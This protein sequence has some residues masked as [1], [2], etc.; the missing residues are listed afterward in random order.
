MR[1]FRIYRTSDTKVIGESP[2]ISEGIFHSTFD[3]SRNLSMLL[4]EKAKENLEVPKAKLKKKA[5][6]VDILS[7]SF[8]SPGQFFIST[9]L[10]NILTKY[11]Y[12]GLEF[13][14]T[15][16]ISNDKE[17]EDYWII[18]PFK[19][20]FSFLDISNSE[21]VFTDSMGSVVNEAI[22]FKDVNEYL[23][24]FEKNKIDA[25]KIG[26]PNFKPLAIH[27]ISLKEETD[28]GAFS[29]SGVYG[30]IGIFVSEVIK[31]EVE[32][33]GCTGIIFTE[34]NER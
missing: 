32:E 8:L 5:K 28:I 18:N 11:E 10:K 6:L 25:I 17:I 19:S 3:S 1:Y 7:A 13:F 4:F 21:F 31:N 29:I 34:L 2:Q 24:V 26:Y 16:I 23:E 15:S 22:K 12:K 14:Q 20:N 30:G 27:K 33:A 9:K